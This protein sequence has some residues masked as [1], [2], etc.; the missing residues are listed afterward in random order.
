MPLRNVLL[1]HFATVMKSVWLAYDAFSIYRIERRDNGFC[2]RNGSTL[3]ATDGRGRFLGRGDGGGLAAVTVTGA[4]LDDAIRGA[5]TVTGDKYT[6]P[7]E[8]LPPVTAPVP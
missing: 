1:F 4:V 2:G 3:K 7:P 5:G 8:P 6:S